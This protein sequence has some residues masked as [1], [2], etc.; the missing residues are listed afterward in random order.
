MALASVLYWVGRYADGQA[1]VEERLAIL[2][3]LGIRD[4]FGLEG[5]AWVCAHQGCYREAGRYLDQAVAI[6]REIDALQLVADALNQRGL[7]AVG[8]G[9]YVEARRLV[10][11]ALAMYHR[12]GLEQA[13]E[14]SQSLLAHAARGLGNG[15]QA[16]DHF[17]R[18]ARAGVDRGA[19]PSLA[20]SLPVAALLLLDEGKTERALEAWESARCLPCVANSRWFEE[21]VGRPV[22]AAAEALPPDIAAAARER[23]KAGDPQATL[24]KLLDELGAKAA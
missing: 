23:G 17:A 24:G 1:A 19:L 9:A 18:A 10:K 11:G 2:H 15:Q 7:I 6:A 8:E 22:A 3:D 14:V 20:Y 21:V 4:S 5:L 13:S 16:R 12:L